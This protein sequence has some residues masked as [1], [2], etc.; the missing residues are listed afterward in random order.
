[1]AFFHLPSKRTALERSR[2]RPGRLGAGTQGNFFVNQL[3]VAE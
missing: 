2:E 3:E 1:M